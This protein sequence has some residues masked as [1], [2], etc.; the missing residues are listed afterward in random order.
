MSKPFK[1]ITVVLPALG[2]ALLAVCSWIC[3]PTTVPFTMQTFAVFTL[4]LL[5][6]PAK[7]AAALLVYIILGS[8]GAPVFSGFQS[9]LSTLL[10]PTGGYIMG[11][12][13][14]ALIY[15]F[16]SSKNIRFQI[17]GLLAGLL[18]CYLFGTIWFVMI[19]ARTQ[20]GI[21]FL[22]AFSWCVLPFIIP[23]LTKLAL[24]VALATRLRPAICSI[25]S[26]RSR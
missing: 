8:I 10:G 5:L 1:P 26:S 23:D 2:A 22:T 11:F 24:A 18:V 16:F 12:L 17:L 19:Y 20:S 4:L 9:G 7:G 15:T 13:L 21:G 14:M 3:I 6:G 25:I